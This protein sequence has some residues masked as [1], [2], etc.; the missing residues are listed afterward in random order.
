M[1]SLTGLGVDLHFTALQSGSRSNT[2]SSC[3]E[4]GRAS[5]R[6]FVAHWCQA[7]AQMVPPTGSSWASPAS[8]CWAGH[9][10]AWH[11]PESLWS[12]MWL[13][14]TQLG[15]P[16]VLRASFVWCVLSPRGEPGSAL[17]LLVLQGLTQDLP[18]SEKRTG[19]ATLVKPV[20]GRR[21]GFRFLRTPQEAKR[22]HKPGQ[23]A[24]LCPVS[25]GGT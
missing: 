8:R 7:G 25:K 3:P 21:E 15:L 10:W 22:R 12:S 9:A 16:R 6:F 4:E 11:R 2:R 13:S 24:C 5:S 19:Q 1:T 18:T 20:H 17:E 23:R 14:G